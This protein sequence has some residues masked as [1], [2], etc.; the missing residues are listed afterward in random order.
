MR[1]RLDLQKKQAP[2]EWWLLLQRAYVCDEIGHLLR[3]YS[4]GVVGMRF[5]HHGCRHLP[6]AVENHAGEL[7]VRFLLHILLVQAGDFHV[8]ELILAEIT[9]T[10]HSVAMDTAV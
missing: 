3:L 4:V 6:P 7:F 5:P 10:A 9:A 1:F 2:A 8:P